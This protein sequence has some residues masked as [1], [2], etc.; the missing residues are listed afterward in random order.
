MY[1]YTFIAIAILSLNIGSARAASSYAVLGY[2]MNEKDTATKISDFV[3]KRISART[4]QPV[5]SEKTAVSKLLAANCTTKQYKDPTQ[6]CI[7]AGKILNADY[8]VY[9][10]IHRSGNKIVI[11]SHMVDAKTGRQVGYTT[12]AED[13]KDKMVFSKAIDTSI[14]KL[15]S[16]KIENQ[17]KPRTISTTTLN[18]PPETVPYRAVTPAFFQL[19]REHVSLGAR[20][21][22]FSMIDDSELHFDDSGK[23]TEGYL[24]SIAYLD[25]SQNYVP[26]I[27]ANITITDW[28]AL[29]LA[30]ERFEIETST[31][32][33]GHSDG[34][35]DMN[36]PSLTAQLRYANHTK[37]TPYLGAG[38][39]MLNVD[40]NME[41][42][43]YNGFSGET[44]EEAQQAYDNWIASG[45]PAWPNG[46]YQRKLVVEDDIA[47]KPV[48]QGGCLWD[49]TDH[50][51][52]DLDLRYISLDT[53]LNYT[54]SRYGNVFS[55]R[56]ESD[57][58][59]S[60][61]IVDLGLV[62]SF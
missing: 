12:V 57:F 1:R 37:F 59:M 54:L 45:A 31:Y 50:F 36:G 9:G 62:V 42:W 32:W 30:W 21:S 56:G 27:Y 18:N 19:I 23:F 8:L 52:L 20:V 49:I 38:I 3:T 47:F 41:G 60:A 24:G 13:P 6:Y 48:F 22:N 26:T 39:V 35:F 14:A 16:K 5:I 28:F 43:W 10:K 4:G 53:S 17:P 46:G 29:Q 7:N 34:T 58:P 33:D 25:P 40:F 15:L 51:A 2:Q 44:G 55:D 61:W 11:N